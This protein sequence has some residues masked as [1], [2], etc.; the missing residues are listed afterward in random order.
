MSAINIQDPLAAEAEAESQPKQTDNLASTSQATTAPSTPSLPP[1]TRVPNFQTDT[2]SITSTTSTSASILS[3]AAETVLGKVE[4]LAP[5]AVTEAAHELA[6]TI[7][8]TKDNILEDTPANTTFSHVLAATHDTETVDGELKVHHQTHQELDWEDTTD[9][10]SFD[11]NTKDSEPF[12]K[13][14]LDEEEYWA[15]IRRF[16]KQMNSVRVIHDREPPGDLDLNISDE[17]EF[18]PDKLRSIMER[19]YT[20]IVSFLP[21]SELLETGG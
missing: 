17:E 19:I 15:L 16:N 2:Q 9:V 18:S 20:T 10:E 3:S 14:S 7:F 12:G 4:S 8:E 13:P 6:S 11:D 1:L 5:P 21:T